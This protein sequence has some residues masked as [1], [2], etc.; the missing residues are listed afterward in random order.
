M[1]GFAVQNTAIMNS[2]ISE[3][4]VWSAKSLSLGFGF[5]FPMVLG[6]LSISSYDRTLKKGLILQGIL[7]AVFIVLSVILG[8]LMLVVFGMGT[9]GFSLGNLIAAIIVFAI[10]ILTNKGFQ[11][12]ITPKKLA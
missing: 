4:V 7:A 1:I 5:A 10:S 6:G 2:N 11:Q 12:L 8:V 9:G 3:L